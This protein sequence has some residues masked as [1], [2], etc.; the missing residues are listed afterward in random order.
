MRRIILVPVLIVLAL[1]AIAGGIAYLIYNNY[2]YYSTDDAQLTGNVI[3]INAIA[4]GQLTTLN[5]G[6]GDSVTIG[7]TIATITPA[8]TTSVTGV[9]TR[10]KPIDITS[11]INGKVIQT[12][13]VSGQT[14][15]PGIAL[16]ELAD[17]NSITVTAYVDEGAIN[18]IKV[19][20]DVDITIDAYSGTSF[21]G[22][23]QQIVPAAASIFSLLPTQDNASGNFTKV[24]Q[25]IPVV[26]TI[27]GNGGKTLA[28][29]M[30]AT[31]T[32]HIH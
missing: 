5:V 26:I 24:G 16:V 6:L 10:V 9:T 17:L 8:P 1:F 7:Q 28:P 23:V 12:S 15:I 20:Q 27:D 11:P 4:T 18:N 3:P 29:G 2:M 32:I 25:R 19:G 22:K 21:T 14:V 13:A 31:T 30:S